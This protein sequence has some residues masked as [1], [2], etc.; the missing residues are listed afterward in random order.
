ML[1]QAAEEM[2][3]DLS[4]S[5]MIGD[6]ERDVQAGQAAGCRAI[7]ID[8]NDEYEQAGHIPA[9]ARVASLSEA[10]DIV[11][12]HGDENPVHSEQSTEQDRGDDYRSLLVEIR[13][14][15]DRAQRT[16]LQDD[17][18][19]ARLFGTLL[20]MLAVFVAAWGIFAML[21]DDI[22]TAL[23]RFGLASFIQLALI[24]LLLSNRRW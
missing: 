21:G 16:T 23:A 20:Q 7:L 19:L 2:D 14:L 8:P 1:L 17:F 18:S 3:L 24:S 11:E 12:K 4:R 6:S 9:D 10:V 13:D 5:W 22:T 15:L